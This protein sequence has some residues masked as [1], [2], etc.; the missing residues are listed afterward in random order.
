VSFIWAAVD[1]RDYLV[2]AR[3]DEGREAVPNALAV[4]RF[5]LSRWGTSHDEP[6]EW[7]SGPGPSIQPSAFH[8]SVVRI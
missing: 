5:A 8:Y 1:L 7:P 4:V 6:H 3:E 2:D